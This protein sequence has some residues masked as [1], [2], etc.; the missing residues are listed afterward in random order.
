MLLPGFEPGISRPQREVLTTTIARWKTE[1][2][3][4]GTL[5]HLLNNKD[6]GTVI[7]FIQTRAVRK[8]KTVLVQN[9]FYSTVICLVYSKQDK[10]SN[11]DDRRWFH[12][13]TREVGILDPFGLR[14]SLMNV[15]RQ[16]S[17][18][19]EQVATL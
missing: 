11:F 9:H 2:L 6:C 13:F 15:H 3:T 18:W 8:T 16:H 5:V 1:G 14:P 19:C 10:S 7:V 4:C 12:L 17:S